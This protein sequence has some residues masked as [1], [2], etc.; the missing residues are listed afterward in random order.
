MDRTEVALRLLVI[1]AAAWLR[2]QKPNTVRLKSKD[3][4][5]TCNLGLE[6]TM[7]YMNCTVQKLEKACQE[8]YYSEMLVRGQ[9]LRRGIDKVSPKIYICWNVLTSKVFNKSRPTCRH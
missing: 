9:D 5:S 4:F 6:V 2:P 7:C 8:N 1:A 3:V